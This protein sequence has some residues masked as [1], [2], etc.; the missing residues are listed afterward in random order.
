MTTQRELENF[1][2]EYDYVYG[3]AE[4][5]SALN[6]NTL[7]LNTSA[8]HSLHEHMKLVYSLRAFK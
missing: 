8:A 5:L 1:E 3:G 4:A 2:V 6:I 7:N